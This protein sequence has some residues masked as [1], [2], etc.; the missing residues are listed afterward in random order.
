MLNELHSAARVLDDNYAT[1]WAAAPSDPLPSLQL[2]LGSVHSIAHQEIRLE[3]AWK[4]YHF[5][6]EVSREGKSWTTLA[7]HRV[8]GFAGSPLLIEKPVE[9][10]YLRLVFTGLENAAPPSIFEWSVR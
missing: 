1:R 9:A 2:D 10:R 8:D 3:Y 7:D 4:T 5:L 6:I